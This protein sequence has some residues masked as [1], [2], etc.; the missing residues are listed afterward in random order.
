M[1][2]P[3]RPFCRILVPM[4]GSDCAH[5]ALLHALSFAHAFRGEVH[6][7]HVV[8]YPDRGNGPLDTHI[9]KALTEIEKKA[10]KH[11]ATLADERPDVGVA[12]HTDACCARTAAMAIIEEARAGAV[13]L[14]V[15]G[16]RGR[17]ST[18]GEE[19]GRTADRVVRYAPCPVLTLGPA[20][21]RAPE[22]VQRILVP[23]DFSP[24]ARRALRLAGEVARRVDAS[25]LV[26]HVIESC[27]CPLFFRDRP[28]VMAL[29][30]PASVDQ[31]K[32]ELR[33]L[34]RAEDVTVQHRILAERARPAEGILT[35]ARRYDAHLI[36]QGICG[37]TNLDEPTLGS[38]A[39][40]V[41]QR[42]HCP[43]ITVKEAS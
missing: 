18:E 14:I 27:R 24:C 7:F 26:L 3:G 20:G 17:H 2:R 22:F 38:V 43:V 42:A 39:A 32:A 29:K 9:R 28:Q 21:G 40:E 30:A 11:L 25:L 13:D 41:V 5:R 36:V 37:H 12:M 16:V 8:E 23:V 33:G 19:A 35:L 4:D 6:L 10:K 15:M 34:A 31:V 1:G